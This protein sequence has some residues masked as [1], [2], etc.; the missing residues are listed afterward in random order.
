MIALVLFENNLVL[1]HS[2]IPGLGDIQ[3]FQHACCIR[4]TSLDWVS[5]SGLYI[6]HKTYTYIKWSCTVK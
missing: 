6:V 3:K 2:P 4:K 1:T 5:D